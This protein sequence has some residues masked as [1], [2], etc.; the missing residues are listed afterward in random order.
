[1]A[2]NVFKKKKTLIPEIYFIELIFKPNFKTL[3]F[4]N[5]GRTFD[6][7]QNNENPILHP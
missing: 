3:F 1:M 6:V 4:F 5:A 7:F 2:K